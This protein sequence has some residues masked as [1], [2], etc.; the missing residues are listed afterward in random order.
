[1][2]S[3]NMKERCEGVMVRPIN[4]KELCD[5]VTKFFRL[6]DVIRQ[7][8]LATLGYDL[9]FLTVDGRRYLLDQECVGKA[10]DDKLEFY[11]DSPD[12]S[13]AVPALA[14]GIKVD[15]VPVLEE[16]SLEEFMGSRFAYNSRIIANMDLWI[17]LAKDKTPVK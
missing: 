1:M 14:V 7:D 16:T 11:R 3:E 5:N 17:R 13:S 8:E 10:F 12:G 6:A 4:V 9:A 15:E 2:D